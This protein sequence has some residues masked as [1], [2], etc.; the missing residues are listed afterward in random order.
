MDTDKIFKTIADV[1]S[2]IIF[3]LF[4]ISTVYWVVAVRIPYLKALVMGV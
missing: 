2:L 1:L 3:G 4:I